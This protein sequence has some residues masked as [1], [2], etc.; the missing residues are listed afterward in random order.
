MNFLGDTKGVLM[1]K[2]P[3]I[4]RVLGDP[5]TSHWLKQSLKLALARE[6]LTAAEDAAMLSQLLDQRCNEHT[7]RAMSSLV[8]HQAKFKW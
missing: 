3:S 5:K 4:T 8:I 6:P 2:N 1:Q 7:Y